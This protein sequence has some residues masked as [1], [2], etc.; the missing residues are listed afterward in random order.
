MT[1]IARYL[2]MLSFVLTGLGSAT[3]VAG[4]QLPGRVL[5]VIDGDTLVL[6]VRGSLY[7]V[8]IA[9]IDAPEQNQPWGPAAAR[10]LSRWV[11][12][13]FVVVDADSV[14]ATNV[15]G[16]IQV[17]RRDLG[18]DLVASGLAWSLFRSDRDALQ[19]AHRP[20]P[21]EL[22]EQEA[23]A[24]KRGLWSDEAPVPPWRWRRPGWLQLSPSP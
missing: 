11:G 20:H 13:T 18:L 19:P 14:D 3:A 4:H 10:E 22:A 17:K 12:G 7:Q 6:D 16:T 9:G 15:S 2:L 8:E 24:A 5:R 1:K 21:Y 23:R